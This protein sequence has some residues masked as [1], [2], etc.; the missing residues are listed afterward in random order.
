MSRGCCHFELQFDHVQ[1]TLWV[2]CGGGGGGGGGGER[3]IPL[4]TVIELEEDNS[5]LAWRKETGNGLWKCAVVCCGG[6]QAIFF[7]IA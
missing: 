5:G 6:H 4:D 7:E 1:S 2:E 3:K